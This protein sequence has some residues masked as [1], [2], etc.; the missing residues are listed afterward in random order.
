MLPIGVVGFMLA[1]L[2]SGFLATF[3]STVN[4]GAAYLVKDVYQRYINPDADNKKL[5]WISY[6][7]STLLIVVGL[8]ISVFGTS[9]N[10][11]F[12]WIFGTLAAGI[13]PPNV[14]RWYWWRLNGQGYAAGVFGGMALSLGQVFV[15]TMYLDKP[16]PLYIGFPVIA[17]ASTLITITVSLLTT[18]TDMETLKNFYRKVQP[19]GAWGPAKDGLLADVPTFKKQ[20][21]FWR[22]AMNTLIAMIGVTSLY[23][24]MLYLVLHRLEIG[25]TLLGTTLTAV[26]VLYFTW[27]KYLPPPSVP[28]SE[29]VQ[30]LEEQLDVDLAR[31]NA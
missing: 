13:L 12:L 31:G 21:P 3:S 26:I 28:P 16:L 7:S 5:V 9:I 30:N 25:F 27:Y 29:D 11:A 1:A 8:I 23:V 10:T 2:L 22:E 6:L 19:A 14:L 4:G 15:D 17:I 20:S 18:A 24:S